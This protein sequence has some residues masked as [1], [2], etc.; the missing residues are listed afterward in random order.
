[1]AI[2]G[3]DFC[4]RIA[5]LKRRLYVRWRFECSELSGVKTSESLWKDRESVEEHKLCQA[6]ECEALPCR[7]K[8]NDD[9]GENEEHAAVEDQKL[10]DLKR[11]R[12]LVGRGYRENENFVRP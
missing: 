8:S 6:A 11:E 1:M 7:I 3:C 10:I 4:H 2:S 5:H 12:R 9:G